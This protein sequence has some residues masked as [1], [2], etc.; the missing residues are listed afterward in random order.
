MLWEFLKIK[1]KNIF[2]SLHIN[3]L[4]EIFTKKQLKIYN[5]FNAKKSNFFS[6]FAFLNS[7]V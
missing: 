5:K 2:R 1:D 7:L 4:G 6:N 3:N